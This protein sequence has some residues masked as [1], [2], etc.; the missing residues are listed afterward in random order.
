MVVRRDFLAAWVVV[1]CAFALPP[2][3]I[4]GAPKEQAEE[5]RAVRVRQTAKFFG[6]I[7][8]LIRA[9]SIFD[10]PPGD[11]L[12]W[13]VR[14][15]YQR[16]KEPLPDALERRLAKSRELNEAGRL[17]L[18]HDALLPLD[19]RRELKAEALADQVMATVLARFDPN[20][21][22]ILEP[23]PFDNWLN[24]PR[25]IGVELVQDPK[26]GFAR[27]V[28][29]IKDGPGYKA[30]LRA[31]DLITHIAFSPDDK[32]KLAEPQATAGVPLDLLQG[33][34]MGPNGTSIRL[35]VRR[36][37]AARPV[38]V[39]VPRGAARAEPLLGRRRLDDDSWSFWLDEK[40]KIGY[41]RLPTFAHSA[42]RL[43]DDFTTVMR[44]LEKR[45]L[46]GL[47]L[48]LRFNEGESLR[49]ANDVTNL[50]LTKGN[51]LT[52][53]ARVVKEK[54]VACEEIGYLSKVPLVVLINGDTAKASE[55]L[56]ACL[57]DHNRAV[58][59]GEK[60]HGSA[61]LQTIEL[62]GN[63]RELLLTIAVMVRPSGKKLDRMPIPG[64]QDSWGV[65]PDSGCSLTL[66]PE[67]RTALQD[68]MARRAS[69][70]HKDQ[71]APGDC[72]ID[73]QLDLARRYLQDQLEK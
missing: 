30:G 20:A 13:T 2:S 35:T 8:A 48:D 60:S 29:P 14:A 72:F 64:Y 10:V 57:Q 33:K 38:E 58:I 31:D 37:G 62:C 68:Y 49:E 50:F 65:T 54:S 59:V 34:L 32:D 26:T 28:T 24:R 22:W 56:A 73:R 4:H 53:H 51:F 47:V 41:I 25:G 3:S 19:Q 7:H 12:D 67:E 23:A 66:P 42:G 43:V 69:L 21:R 5:V 40:G 63:C 1:V 39:L 17:L 6:E 46:R 45:G 71:P 52:I 18:F 27:V 61:S 9:N 11:L 15:L 44:N 36:A 70:R 55:A 16:H